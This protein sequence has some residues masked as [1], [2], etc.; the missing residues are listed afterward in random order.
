MIAMAAG[1]LLAR[2]RVADDAEGQREDAGGRALDDPAGDEHLDRARERVDDAAGGEERHDDGEHAP[3]AVEVAELADDRRRDRRREQERGEDPGGRGG[4]RAELLA[5]LRQ[6]R[7]DERLRERERHA[8]EEQDGEDARRV[9][10]RG[11]GLG[12]GLREA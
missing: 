8:R 10:G 4:A 12:H 9:L 3:L 6:R 1:D 7:D 5:D 2:E 11:G